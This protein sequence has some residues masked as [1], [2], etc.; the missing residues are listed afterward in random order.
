MKELKTIGLTNVLKEEYE[1]R[2]K[3]KRD[4]RARESYVRKE[5]IAIGKAEGKAEAILE[6]LK[7][8][9]AVP[10]D[11]VR[12]IMN[13]RDPVVLS[14]WLKLASKVNSVRE[15]VNQID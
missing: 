3:A 15:F 4:A 7:E 8:L 6:L 12:T 11:I 10:E 13:E 5:G 2:L 14:R 9:G 1:S